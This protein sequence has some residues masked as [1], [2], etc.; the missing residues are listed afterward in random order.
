[1]TNGIDTQTFRYLIF[2]SLFKVSFEIYLLFWRK[3]FLIFWIQPA[4]YFSMNTQTRILSV[5]YQH[6]DFSI[7]QFNWRWTVRGMTFGLWADLKLLELCVSWIR[8]HLL[9]TWLKT[10][11]MKFSNSQMQGKTLM[12]HDQIIHPTRHF[13]FEADGRLIE[14]AN[15]I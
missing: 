11:T 4:N 13:E 3:F 12:C 14:H 9:W 5:A 15:K 6:T 2:P 8:C 10:W 1:M 7:W